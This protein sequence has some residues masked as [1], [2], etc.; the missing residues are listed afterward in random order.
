MDE[1]RGTSQGNF[2]SEA[3]WGTA[4]NCD[5]CDVLMGG[6]GGGGAE[7]AW[8]NSES[9]TIRGAAEGHCLRSYISSR[10]SNS[11]F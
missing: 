3:G 1:D 10:P 11:V 8:G 2:Y 4:T 7:R 9:R 5:I 6:R